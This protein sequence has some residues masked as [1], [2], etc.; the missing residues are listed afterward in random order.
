[1]KKLREAT[2]QEIY[3]KYFQGKI[4]PD[5]FRTVISFDPTSQVKESL[6]NSVLGKYSQ[7]L[8]KNY[9]A[10]SPTERN[11]FLT[12][13]EEFIKRGLSLFRN[14]TQNKDG[15]QELKNLVQLYNIPVINVSDINQYAIEDISYLGATES[16]EDSELYS[17]PLEKQVEVIINDSVMF[18][19]SP[20]T[21]AASRKYGTGTNWCTATS[22]PSWFQSYISRGPLFIIIDK[23]S[24]YAE[25]W[26]YHHENKELRNKFN[27]TVSIKDLILYWYAKSEAHAEAMS[28]FAGYLEANMRYPEWNYEAIFSDKESLPGK[29]IKALLEMYPKETLYHGHFSYKL[30]FE[31]RTN[32][33][34]LKGSSN[35]Y[36]LMGIL[37]SGLEASTEF[38]E[39]LNDLYER[40]FRTDEFDVIGFRYSK[41]LPYVFQYNPD[42]IQKYAEKGFHSNI[43]LALKSL[44]VTPAGTPILY[45]IAQIV[46]K[47]SLEERAYFI[48]NNITEASIL[49]FN[50][51]QFQEDIMSNIDNLLA[52]LISTILPELQEQTQVLPRIHEARAI[53]NKEPFDFESIEST[54]SSMPQGASLIEKLRSYLKKII[55]HAFVQVHIFLA[56]IPSKYQKEAWQSL[57]YYSVFEDESLNS[58]RKHKIFSKIKSNYSKI[59]FYNA[60]G[61]YLHLCLR[62]EG[63][64]SVR[65]ILEGELN[66]L[67]N[68]LSSINNISKLAKEQG[69]PPQELKRFI[70]YSLA[71]FVISLPAKEVIGS[72]RNSLNYGSSP[73]ITYL[74][75]RYVM[76][77][78]ATPK[79]IQSTFSNPKKVVIRFAIMPKKEEIIVSAIPAS[80]ELEKAIQELLPLVDEIVKTVILIIYEKLKFQISEEKDPFYSIKN[81]FDSISKEKP[82][83][84]LNDFLGIQEYCNYTKF[85]IHDSH[86]K[87]D[88]KEF[89]IKLLQRKI[90]TS[91]NNLRIQRYKDLLEEI[92]NTPV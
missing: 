82:I 35:E 56:D 3:N 64:D 77:L 2:A 90:R 38:L 15:L 8:L 47:K 85:S 12:E 42:L 39:A 52:A 70:F 58:Y 28:T 84:M 19:C 75:G 88:F 22:N 72:L 23:T 4:T 89:C 44:F 6:E 45:N 51:F 32:H 16:V 87:K 57:V 76:A 1:M 78:T 55:P 66:T 61:L 59:I 73:I 79:T 48:Y 9:V 25:K 71:K 41:L 68:D 29:V 14:Y 18:A 65:H 74:F 54:A 13:D 30:E 92:V 20:K 83:F 53:P 11:Q 36:T 5:E 17:T 24:N 37:I 62:K 40:G 26:Q 67:T 21:H 60:L 69:K 10:L 27:M 31:G 46:A 33:A 80:N 34:S 50:G 86:L 91:K 49:E 63:L 81:I 43:F 7:W